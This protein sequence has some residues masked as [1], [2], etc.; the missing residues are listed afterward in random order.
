MRAG[1]L[2]GAVL[3]TALVL[4]MT[5]T[6][7]AAPLAAS[8]PVTSSPDNGP[9]A[10][11]AGPATVANARIRKVLSTRTRSSVLG[12]RFTM[13]VRDADAHGWVYLRRP[14]V[15]LRGA[16]TTKILT[17]VAALH[18]LGPNRRLPTAVRKG[19]TT[20]DLVLVAGGDPLLTSADLRLLA[21]R[22]KAGLKRAGHSLR[23]PYALRA[24]DS[25]FTGNPIS[26]GWL[27]GWVPRQVR[28]VGAFARDDRKV[29]D[30]TRDAGRYFA[31][32]LRAIGVKA[33][34]RGEATAAPRAATW[35]AIPGHTVGAAVRHALLVSDNDTAEM[36]FRLNAIANKRP[37]TW[38]GA[39][40]AQAA[41]L[42]RLGV[43]MAKVKV[44]DGSGLSLTGRLT[45]PALT[46][47]L[48]AAVSPKHPELAPLRRYL[49]VAGRTGT[50]SAAHSRFTTSPAKCAA[51]RIQAKTGTLADAIS[52]AGY[53]QGA[54]GGTKVFVAVVNS[55]PTKYSR[56]TTRK[57]VDKVTASVTGCW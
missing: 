30:A 34:Y 7:S 21:A 53:A 9:V 28:P 27:R 11:A 47:A 38:A 5:L 49:P 55:R 16:S 4:G 41:V 42:R 15:S 35:A 18:S 25:L 19:R 13:T 1:I 2:R 48:A 23:Y 40:Q 20:A 50:L 22:T 44:I 12:P 24:D 36:L 46:M 54:D 57:A 3:G 6:S 10:A 52:L 37:P 14:L 56:Q 43:P 8:K 39:R 17:A 45:A 33:T 29:R 51:G 32:A 31:S 26:R